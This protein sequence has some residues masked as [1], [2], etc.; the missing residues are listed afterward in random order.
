MAHAHVDLLLDPA[1][2]D[3]DPRSDDNPDDLAQGLR[4][5]WAVPSGPI[6]GMISTL[7]EH[8]IVCIYRDLSDLG[9]ATLA[10]TA[11]SG[12]MLMFIDTAATRLDLVWSLAHELGH[13]VL[14]GEPSKEQ[15]ARAEAFASAFLLP[16]SDLR[17]DDS[18]GSSINLG[19]EASRC[20]VR[21]RQ[22]AQRL[23]DL[24]M[25]THVQFR[26][27]IHEAAG[28]GDEQPN[29]AL[30]GRPSALADRVRDAGGSRRAALPAFLTADELRQRYLARS[31]S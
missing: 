26:Q 29:P 14:A 11:A 4:D 8:G 22:L 2:P 5:R 23:R 12:R 15:E 16:A 30:L 17:A 31:Q 19:G 1:Q 28:I 27:V 10:S 21:P 6:S 18:P 7:E 3:L 20:G 24:K 25:I 13:L 9:A